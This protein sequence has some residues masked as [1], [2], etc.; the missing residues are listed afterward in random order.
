MVIASSG[1][2]SAPTGSSVW[3]ERDG[4]HSREVCCEGR[5]LEPQRPLGL[6]E[7][8]ER[9]LCL[10]SLRVRLRKVDP[11]LEGEGGGSEGD[12]FLDDAR[13]IVD[14]GIEVPAHD[15][16]TSKLRLGEQG[17]CYLAG[18]TKNV[19]G[20]VQHLRR[21]IQGASADQNLAEIRSGPGGLR[22]V[23]E[24]LELVP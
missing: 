15:C 9:M 4:S 2:S 1:C 8:L 5:R 11:C 13:E 23:A 6:L 3:A 19:P 14:R 10:S 20:V 7:G 16:E 22:G 21:L 12:G 18:R 17:A 24:A